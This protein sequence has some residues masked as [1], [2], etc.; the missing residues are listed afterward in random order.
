MKKQMFR[1][2]DPNEGGSGA[3]AYANWL[4][5]ANKTDD[6]LLQ[7]RQAFVATKTE[8]EWKSESAAAGKDIITLQRDA[9]NDSLKAPAAAEF[10]P[11]PLWNEL[12]GVDGFVMPVDLTSENE[13]VL[14]KKALVDGGLASGEVTPKPNDNP[15]NAPVVDPEYNA[16]LTWKEL[17]PD[18]GL[19]D[20]VMDNTEDLAYLKF[21]DQDFMDEYYKR[22]YGIY[23]EVKNPDGLTQQQI[24]DA[25]ETLSTSNQLPIE[26]R[27]LKSSIIKN[28]DTLA[29]D[30]RAETQRT[31]EANRVTSQQAIETDLQ[32]LFVETN[33]ITELNGVK[34]SKADVTSINDA[35]KKAVLPD[36]QGNVPIVEMLR[37]NDNLWKFFAVQF[38]GDSRVKDALF[39]AT[40][41]TKDELIKK[42]GLTPRLSGGRQSDLGKGTNVITPSKWAEPDQSDV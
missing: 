35:F 3:D 22:E 34:I 18:K 8:D 42:L 26:A 7:E 14:L 32:K 40:D 10:T 29:Q 21:S 19:N 36:T 15:V 37:S 25:I 41:S 27:K 20:Y 38:Q 17:N 5:A 31:V 16:Y 12:S 23:D 4:S 11:N 28:Q 30:K 1:S 24:D 39:N 6:E 33:K 2:P 13:T 9:W